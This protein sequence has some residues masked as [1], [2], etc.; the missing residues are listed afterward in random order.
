MSSSLTSDIKENVYKALGLAFVSSA[1]A[2][3][4]IDDAIGGSV[5]RTLSGVL[6]PNVVGPLAYGSVVFVAGLAYLMF[7]DDSIESFFRKIY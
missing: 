1:I 6:P 3:I 4:G 2:F 5:A 7:M